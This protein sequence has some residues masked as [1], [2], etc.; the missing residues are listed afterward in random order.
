MPPVGE[1]V[2]FSK[3]KL[4]QVAAQHFH[5]TIADF[6]VVMSDSVEKGIRS[7]EFIIDKSRWTLGIGISISKKKQNV[8]CFTIHSSGLRNSPAGFKL[9]IVDSRG[10]ELSI[11]KSGRWQYFTADDK[12]MD[13]GSLAIEDFNE[14]YLQ[15]RTS[16]FL[17]CEA[18]IM[19][20][21]IQK[22]MKLEKG[23]VGGE[24]VDFT[25]EL[26]KLADA[27]GNDDIK[28]FCELKLADSLNVENVS[29]I[30]VAAET[31]G[32]QHLKSRIFEFISLNKVSLING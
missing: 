11:F 23:K 25:V 27:R 21:G 28:E 1:I 13:F 12:S 32:A 10:R 26:L 3:F 20:S 29:K 18:I 7:S 17:V 22:E 14:M 5:W 31:S 30:F 8:Y 9:S 2:S 15:W 24:T 19:P 6:P 4:M 16:L